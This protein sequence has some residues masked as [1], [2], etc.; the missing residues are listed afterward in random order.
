MIVIALGDT[1][2][3]RVGAAVALVALYASYWGVGRTHMRG[4]GGSAPV[5]VPLGTVAIFA[6]GLAF[7]PA[8]AARVE[9]L[10]CHARRP[11]AATLPR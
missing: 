11:R 5:L 8:E 4:D 10:H 2:V 9:A 7:E 3:E 1:V 6:I